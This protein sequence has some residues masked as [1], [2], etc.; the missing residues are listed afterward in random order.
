MVTRNIKY[1]NDFF[2]TL[3]KSNPDIFFEEALQGNWDILPVNPQKQA[4]A[5]RKKFKKKTHDSKGQTHAL[6]EKLASYIEKQEIKASLPKLF[7]LYRAFL[8]VI[9]ENMDIID[10]SYGVIGDLSISVF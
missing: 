9:L 8:T 10:D 3:E 5:L 4:E 6:E 7:A 1:G 2:K